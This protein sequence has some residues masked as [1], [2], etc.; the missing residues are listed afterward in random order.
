MVDDASPRQASRPRPP[1]LRDLATKLGVS[2]TAVARGLRGDPGISPVLRRRIQEVARHHGYVVSDLT[3]ALITG[4]SDTVGVVVPT[5][6]SSFVSE[7]ADHLVQALWE[8]KLLPFVLCS[9]L[10]LE[11]EEQ[12]LRRLA[13]KRVDG[14]VMMPSREDPGRDHFAQLLDQHTPI[15]ALNNPLPEL[16]LPLVS[17][18][19]ALGAR[20]VTEHLI[21]QGHRHIL[22]LGSALDSPHADRRREEGYIDAMH[23]AGL[24]PRIV[25]SPKRLPAMSELE[26]LLADYLESGAGADVTAI[27]CFNDNL[28]LSAYRYAARRGL[29]IGRDLAV[30]GFG[31]VRGTPAP[32]PD[33]VDLIEPP[34][35]TVEQRPAIM[36]RQAVHAM[37]QLVQGKTVPKRIMVKPELILRESTTGWAGR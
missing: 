33:P 7:L 25:H 15:I 3:Q 32:I 1:S 35:T 17:S 9:E 14:V 2:H 5:L 12:M 8:S 10:N 18:D 23:R 37:R 34:L 22:H 11:T 26:A 36:A 24:R 28:A 31:N 21:E 4:Q 29:R 16:N 6:R 30:A 13:A 19:D 27:F 20:W